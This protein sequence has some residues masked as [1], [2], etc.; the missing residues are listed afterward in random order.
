MTS[1]DYILHAKD[2]IC[3]YSSSEGPIK[4]VTV[5]KLRIPRV[6]VTVIVGASGSGK[7]TL[8]S[9]LSGTRRPTV[10]KKSSKLTFFDTSTDA[11]IDLIGDNAAAKGRLGFVFQEPYLIKE[12][13]GRS[14]AEIAAEFLKNNNEQLGVEELS[15]EF[16]VHA[17]LDQR[18]DTLSGGQAQRIAIIRALAINPDVLICDEPT[19]SL[20][21]STGLTLL[22][23]IHTWAHKNGKAVLLVTHNIQQAARFG[24]YFIKVEDGKIETDSDGAPIFLGDKTYHEKF[25][26]L[27]NLD[28]KKNSDVVETEKFAF[29]QIVSKS[30]DANKSWLIFV[31]K[32]VIESFY[33]GNTL[34]E[35]RS[36]IGMFVR[37]WWAPFKQFSVIGLLVLGLLVF[38]ALLKAQSVGNQY[39]EEVLSKPELSHFT[40]QQTNEFPLNIQNTIKLKTALAARSGGSSSGVLFTRRETFL[41]AVV[42]SANGECHTN[43][44]S[45]NAPML[46]FQ[47]DEPLYEDFIATSAD[48]A[49][50]SDVIYATKGYFGKTDTDYL[51]VDIDG[52]FLPF[53]V[54]WIERPLPGGSDRTFVLGLTEKQ[55]SEASSKIES[56]NY[57]NLTYSEAA[58]YFNKNNKD[59][60]L[61]SFEDTGNCIGIAPLPIKFEINKD[62]FIQIEKFTSLSYLA[63]QAI[64]TL[65][66]SFATVMLAAL[67]F[68]MGSEIKAQEKSL[69]ILRAFGVSG[70]QISVFFQIKALIQLTYALSVAVILFIMGRTYLEVLRDRQ[71]FNIDLTLS[72]TDLLSPLFVTLLLTQLTT[73]IVVRS[74]AQKNKFVA[75]KL[76]GL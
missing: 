35:K 4:G 14:N 20:D 47:K 54:N 39:F 5:E 6:G 73:I 40:I 34:D 59:R 13:S 27:K 10:V 42:P 8:L 33:L 68:A 21:A 44:K 49:S 65:V 31:L 50:R 67:G 51:C 19:S 3:N 41:Q 9:L 2:L 11:E 1:K 46:V 36:H 29:N 45:L 48:S 74:W 64:L 60:V 17:V 15:K 62:V 22:G 76:Q 61:C 38:T 53:K 43:S 70:H 25:S 26:F 23:T 75:E 7:S 24:D 72:Y 52:D 57:Q 63:Q 28:E 32:I 12:I 71:N 30:T 55:F 56:K 18:A 66:V 69:A 58:V 16:G 37:S